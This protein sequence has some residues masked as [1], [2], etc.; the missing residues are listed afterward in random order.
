MYNA[1]GIRHAWRVAVGGL[2]T[3]SLGLGVSVSEGMD[4]KGIALGFAIAGVAAFGFAGA[5]SAQQAPAEVGAVAETCYELGFR[6]S[7]CSQAIETAL[8]VETVGNVNAALAD[9]GILFVIE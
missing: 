8:V 5:A 6:I 1:V 4:M 2:S 3:M 9:A 7:D